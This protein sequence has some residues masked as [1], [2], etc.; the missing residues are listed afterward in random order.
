MFAIPSK[1]LWLAQRRICTRTVGVG[2]TP[3]GQQRANLELT[4]GVAG[5]PHSCGP[6]KG[7]L[8]HTISGIGWR[9]PAIRHS[10]GV[11]IP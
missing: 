8:S 6:T 11:R 7:Q 4:N 3:L 5:W 10:M 2:G 9:L 1:Q